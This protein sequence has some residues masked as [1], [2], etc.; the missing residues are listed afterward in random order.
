MNLFNATQWVQTIVFVLLVACSQF[1]LSNYLRGVPSTVHWLLAIIPCKF[2]CGGFE[3]SECKC[4]FG[5]SGLEQ[6]TLKQR[7]PTLLCQ[8][9]NA[10]EKSLAGN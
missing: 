3:S 4:G 5:L 10:Y 1:F 7:R 8:Y 6:R 2:L 9:A